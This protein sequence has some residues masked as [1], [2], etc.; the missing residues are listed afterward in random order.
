MSEKLL[1]IDGNSIFC[2]AYYS[3][4]PDFMTSTGIPTKATYGFTNMLIHVVQRV[5]PTHILVAFDTPAKTFRKKM[6]DEYKANREKE[7]N[8]DF[9]S[10]FKWVKKLLDSLGVKHVNIAGY[11]ADDIIGTYATIS[12]KET[13][14]LTGD[15]DAFQLIN[16]NVSVYFPIKGVSEINVVDKEGFCS[17]Y[18]DITTDQ[19]IDLKALM[20]DD[21]DNVPGV[22]GVGLKTGI[23]LLKSYK[24]LDGIIANSGHIKGKC[25]QRIRD[26]IDQLIVNKKLV[27]ILTDIE[28]PYTIEDCKI[29]FDLSKAKQ[30]FE[31]LEFNSFL[32]LIGIQKQAPPIEFD[33]WEDL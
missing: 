23:K 7:K 17:M 27:T 8:E 31:E 6:F 20:G 16:K 25:G 2:R 10:Q 26:H 22:H 14:I 28:V 1:I 18:E 29:D 33:S 13:I 32:K 21:S 12:D 9:G 15:K 3:P 11:E 5:Q 4:M 19:F 24:S 30:I